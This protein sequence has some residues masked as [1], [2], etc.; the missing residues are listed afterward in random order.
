MT[1]SL[2]AACDLVIVLPHLGPGG[3][4]KVALMAAEHFLAQGRHVTL[5]TLLADK[6][7]THSLPDGLRWVDLGHAV[8]ATRSNRAA[9]ARLWRFSCTWVR[10][11][12][13]WITLLFGWNVVKRLVP[14]QAPSFVQWLVTS[15]SGV[16]ASLLRD[17]LGAGKPVRVLSLLTRTN[18]LCCQAMWALPGHLVVSERNDPRLQKQAFPWPRLRS[19]LWQRADVIT[20][21]TLGVLEGLQQC[22]PTM[23][24]DMRLL[25]N[26][27]VVDS[28]S[29]H[30]L[31]GPELDPYFLAVCRLVPQKGIDLLIEAYAQL[32]APLRETWPLLVA[33]DGPERGSLETLAASLELQGQVRFL[34]FQHNPQTLYRRNAVFVLS[35]RFEGMP[36]S[37]LEAM[38]NGLPVIVS[39]ASPGPLEVVIHDQSGLVVPSEKVTLLSEAMRSMAK[40]SALRRRLGDAA[41]EVMHA[42]SWDKLDSV[43]TQILGFEA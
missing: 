40:D 36:N 41:I 24:D 11:S 39:D 20:A 7:C 27:L 30:P 34:G 16:Q 13:A 12:L 14:G 5:V 32:P 26:P 1:A 9:M 22:H 6:P 25:P 23:A 37:L 18:L 21:N 2:P 38:G 19:W 10:R 28:L 4:Q 29:V 31:D 15:T 3:A 33:G 17:L 35:S 43:W 8:A 42:Y